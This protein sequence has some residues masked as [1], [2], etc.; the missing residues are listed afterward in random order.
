MAKGH[1]HAVDYWSYGILMF[2]LLV[3]RAPF[4]VPNQPQ[5]TMFKRIVLVQYD[6]PTFMEE[7]G[8]DLISK[9]LVRRVS[10]RLGV[11]KNGF[12]DIRDHEFFSNNGIDPR[13]LLMKE[14]AAP[15]VPK[16]KNPL[17]SQYFQDFSRIEKEPVPGPP[18][19]NQEQALFEEF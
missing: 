4:S 1:N 6:F 7:S 10:T 14:I 8:R 3:G 17:D 11:Q 19:T 15:W 13:K 2:E 18:L 9:L 16:V 12:L 5:M